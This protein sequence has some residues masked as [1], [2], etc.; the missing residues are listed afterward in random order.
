MATAEAAT[1]LPATSNMRI[2]ISIFT[3]CKIL[4][5][6]VHIFAYCQGIFFYLTF[7]E[8]LSIAFL[9]VVNL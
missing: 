8:E 3:K 2:G 1:K 4:Y 5:I 9:W 7:A 6:L